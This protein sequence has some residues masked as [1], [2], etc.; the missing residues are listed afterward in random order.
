MHIN[1]YN[2]FPPVRLVNQST[3]LAKK[4]TSFSLIGLCVSY[5]YFET[6]Q[7]MLP[8]NYNHFT[9]IYL[10]TQEDDIQTIEFCKYFDN[11]EVILFNFK[12]NKANFNKGGGLIKIQELAYK[13]Y[14]DSW[15]LIIDSDIILP[16]NFIDLIKSQNLNEN[17]IYGG[18]RNNLNKLSDIHLF[19]NNEFNF[20]KHNKLN[21]IIGCF[22][23][24]KLKYYYQ[25]SDDSYFYGA[26]Y[27][28]A[29][30]NVFDNKKLLNV[31]YLHLGKES[32]YKETNNWTTKQVPFLCDIS[33]NI[34]NLLF[35]TSILHGFLLDYTWNISGELK[36]D[37]ITFFKNKHYSVASDTSFLITHFKEVFE[38]L[39]VYNTDKNL[40]SRLN[41]KNANLLFTDKSILSV[42]SID[43]IFID[44]VAIIN[45]NHN[46]FTYV[47]SI[48]ENID[49]KYI[50]FFNLS[51]YSLYKFIDKHKYLINKKNIGLHNRLNLNNNK[52]SFTEGLIV[53]NIYCKEQ[54]L[55]S[56]WNNKLRHI[57]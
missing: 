8:L 57:I 48:I 24:Y 54:L 10:V 17:Y 45:L 1:Y 52:T 16:A 41:M 11:V 56:K 6:L 28:I 20:D 12:S 33:I 15:Y 26:D 39:T 31:V 2:K 35:E 22:Q 13:N 7:I 38:N 14:P 49:V 40:I 9:H 30:S 23:L 32:N 50:I 25:E 43:I 46:I 19:L 51:F 27:D 4:N 55:L 53:Q 36:K 5:N 42:E 44:I 47:N 37:I 21:L 3:T 34:T 18:Y 29:F